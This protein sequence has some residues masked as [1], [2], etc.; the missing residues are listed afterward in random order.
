MVYAVDREHEELIQVVVDQVEQRW[1]RERADDVAAFLRLYYE[2]ASP[3]DLTQRNPADLYGAAIFHWQLAQ[4]RRPGIPLIQVYNPSPERHGWESTHTIAQVVTDDMPFLVDSLSLAMNRLG[5]TLHL[6]I[7]PVMEATRDGNGRLQ[8]VRALDP[9]AQA[10]QGAEAFMHFE[11][12]RQSGDEALNALREE[13][14]KVLRAVRHAVEDW[15]PMRERMRRCI[16]NLKRNPPPEND[17]DLSEVCDFLDWLSD[18]HFTYLGYRKYDLREERGELQ[19]RPQ[20]ETGLGIL[21]D[22]EGGRS[23]SFSTLPAAVRRKALEPCP[24]VITKSN[25]RSLVHRPGYMDYIGIKR[26]DRNGKVIGEHRFLGLYTSA[27]YNRNPRAIPLLRQRIQRVIDRSGLHPRSHAGKALVNIMETYPRDELFQI[28]TDTL[29]RTVLGILHLQE[30]QRVRL[31]ARHDDYQRFVSCLVYA[32][33]ERYNTEVREQMQAILQE[34][35]GGTRSEFT[36]QLSE[37]VLARIHFIIRL[38]RPGIP[39]YDTAALERHLAA[40]MRSWRDDLH[41]ALVEHFGEEVGNALHTRYGRAF[42]AAYREDVS[43]RTAVLDVSRMERLEA[44]DL[45][46][47]LYRALEAPP[48]ELRLKLLKL[49]DP[50]VLSDALPVLE[51]MGVEVL[52]ERPYEVRPADRPTGWMHDFGLRYPG[53][54]D[55]NLDTVREPFQEAFIRVWHGELE[56]D[57]F[58]RLILAARLKPREVVILRAYCKYL[59]QAGTPFSQSYI[60]D[61][62]S[63]NAEIARLLV[64]MFRARFHPRYQ[65]ARREARLATEIDTALRDVASLDEDRILRRYLAA[66]QATRRT[67]YYRG[68]AAGEPVEHIAF[69][70]SPETIPGVPRPHPWAE[71]YVYS[72]RVEGVHLRGGPV[73]RG[74]LRWSDRREDFRSEILGLM[75]AQTVKNA[76][77]V[78]VGA[79]GGFVVK[80]H[81]QDREA[82]ADEVRR[83][84]QGFIRALLDVTDNRVAGE[85]QPPPEVVRHDADDPYLVVAADKGTATFSDLANAIAAEYDFWLGDAFASGGAHGY[86]HKKMGITARGAWEAVKRH[87]RELGRDIQNEPFTVAGIGDMSGDVFGNGMLLSRHI[88]LV[89][90]F[91]HRHIFIDPDP[92]AETGYAERERLFRLPRSSWADYDKALISEGGG[93]WPRSAKSIPLTP[94]VRQVLQI[95][96]QQLTPAELIR[97]ILAAPLDLLWNG[98]IGTYVKASAESHT[99]VGDRS[100]EDTRIDASELRVKVF[101]EGGNLGITQRGRIE[102]ARRGGHINTDAIDNSGGV[103]CSDHEVN[104]K[105]LLKEVVD[106]GDLTVKH[107]NQLLEDM[108]ESVAELVLADN[109]AQTGALSLAE[110]AA[111]ELLNEQVRFIRRLERDGRLNRRLEALPDE[112]ELAERAAAAQGLT[113]PETAVLLAY[114]KIVAQEA[115]AHSDLPEEAWLQ[116][117]LHAYFPAPIR[118]RWGDRIASHRLRREIIATQVANLL[119][120]RLGPTFFFRMGEKAS[121]PADAVTRAAYAAMEVFALDGL[122]RAVCALDTRVAASHQ[123]TML[124]TVQALHERAT[125]WLLRNLGTRLD[126]GETVQ[127]MQPQVANLQPR[128]LALLPIQDREELEGRAGTLASGDV[129]AELARQAGTLEALYPA[130]DLVKVAQETDCDLERVAALYFG[131]AQQLGLDWLRRAITSFVPADAWQERLRLGLE[132]D[133]YQHLRELTRDLVRDSDPAAAPEECLSQFLSDFGPAVDRVEQL[134]SELRSVGH[135]ELPMLAVT[136]QELKNLAQA[137]AASGP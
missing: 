9:D 102:F 77:I 30:R 86:D 35:L 78:P 65:D 62:L 91:D 136:T 54:E 88:R 84:Y 22:R 63:R 26:Y 90:A 68:V 124:S 99:D 122:W 18:N 17:D 42:S 66:I 20:R 23:T 56:D 36:V 25:S 44:G 106:D 51:N 98:G 115:L 119:I 73:A 64:R 71:I 87:F 134:L 1:P 93:V 83:C 41:D 14:E 75:K 110:A 27:A 123:R 89:A 28:S 55:L 92:D 38:D 114:G 16:T 70:L 113:R 137:G 6:V 15:Q 132:E 24:L 67:S 34:E 33:R 60:E 19:L 96:A 129:P 76:V 112:E 10:V 108:T 50:I 125:L 109:Y 79:K 29:Y 85:L 3:E 8:A 37:S 127:R 128:L 39:E 126:I 111:P 118:E 80:R 11:V 40:T 82:M 59:R 53:A 32:P 4:K 7:H 43:P 49:G 2:D 12:D 100:T 72:P 131:L 58:N 117:V 101:G 130:L 103:D 97:A 120:N 69:K 94:Q 57:G 61:T 48:D 52:D 5:L 21:R 31:F 74:G 47:S 116:D 135:V 46:M 81:L 45:A 121:A 105:I 133:Y 107:R 104:I 95:D 13:L